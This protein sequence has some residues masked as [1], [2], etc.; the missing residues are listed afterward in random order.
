MLALVTRDDLSELVE[1]TGEPGPRE[2][3]TVE[4]RRQLLEDQCVVEDLDVT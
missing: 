4:R 1:L 2:R 3:L